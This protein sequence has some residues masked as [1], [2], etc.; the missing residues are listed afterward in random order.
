MKI[1]ELRATPIAVSDPPLLNAAGLHA[2]YALRIIVELVTDRGIYGL[3]EIP[4]SSAALAAYDAIRDVVVGRDPYQRTAIRRAIEERLAG[5][6]PDPKALYAARQLALRVH[7]GID[8]ALFDIIGKDSGRPV[9]D[10]LGGRVRDRVDFAAY[11]FYKY[12]GSGGEFGFERDQ[13]AA[14]WEKDLQAAALDPAGLVAQAQAMVKRFGFAS[15]KLKGGVFEPR[16]ETDTMLA[17]RDAF[18]PSMPLRIDPNA[19]W[20]LETSIKYGKELEGVLQYFED[21]CRGQETMAALR[22]AIKIPLATNMCTT[23]FDELPGSI[24]HGSEDIILSDHHIWGGLQASMDLSRVCRTFGRKLSMHSNS[25]VGISFAAMIHLAG[26]LDELAYEADTHYPWQ[27]E[28][29]I[30]GGKIKIEDGAVEVP[31]EPGL[32]VELDREALARLHANYLRCGIEDRD[33]EIE[34]QK[35]VP[36][37]KFQATRW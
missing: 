25:H 9:V 23:N 24:R 5:S 13:A 30:V 37:W 3:G 12:E 1:Q 14:G 4:G 22:K 31:R 26:A 2:P 19:L 27:R 7:S 21:P 29:V 33:D 15:L 28:E 18:G 20:S 16:V 36:G 35:K 6:A 32:G 17:L 11:L 10:I 8:V 34:M